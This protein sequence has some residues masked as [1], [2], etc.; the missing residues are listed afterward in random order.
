MQKTNRITEQELKRQQREQTE[1][2]RPTPPKTKTL[3]KVV[4][5]PND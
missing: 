3:E 5:E 4:E 2:K 1:R